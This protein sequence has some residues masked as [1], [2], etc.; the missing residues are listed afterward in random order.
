M[1]I[2]IGTPAYNGQIHIDYL[3]SILD[4]HKNRMPV[5]VMSIGNESLI[6][7]GRNTVLSYFHSMKEFTHLLFLDADIGIQATDVAKLLQHNVDVIGAPVPL[8]GY[9]A[10]GKKVFNVNN[11]IRSKDNPML[12]E[13]DKVGTAVFMLSRKAV[14]SL[15]NNAIEKND[16]YNRNE[17]TRG[18][19]ADVL[20]YDVFKTGVENG[21]YLSEDF[22]VC[23]VLK[24]LG[25]KIFVDDTIIVKHNG[26]FQF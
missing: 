19:N 14:D 9:D 7:R 3:N 18:V 13:V 1:N 17:Y 25:Y 20:M 2:L 12:Y 6:T 5:N 10:Q 15:V 8:K 24:E 23:K 21:N 16:I 26:I 11:P 22:Y 4:M